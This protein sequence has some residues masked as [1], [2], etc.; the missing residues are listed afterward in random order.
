MS[1]KIFCQIKYFDPYAL[2]SSYFE[3]SS[4]TFQH[5]KRKSFDVPNKRPLEVT[6]KGL[7]LKKLKYYMHCQKL[8]KTGI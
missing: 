6:R 5:S 1:C 3:V 4:L 7:R 2:V 8:M